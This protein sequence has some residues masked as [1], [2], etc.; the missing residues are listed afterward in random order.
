[1]PGVVEQRGD[2]MTNTKRMCPWVLILALAAP[3]AGGETFHGSRWYPVDQSFH[4]DREILGSAETRGVAN[5]HGAW[6]SIDQRA[7]D[8]DRAFGGVPRPVGTVYP[9]AVLRPAGAEPPDAP[10]LAEDRSFHGDRSFHADRTFHGGRLC[11]PA[12]PRFPP[13][14]EW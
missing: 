13:F 2:D 1:M 6:S 3:G 7:L 10:R 8:A 4:A 5:Y 9:P 12:T 11:K 14:N